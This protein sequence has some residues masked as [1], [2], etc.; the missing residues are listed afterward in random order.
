MLVS[1]KIKDS[2][3]IPNLQSTFLRGLFHFIPLYP[4]GSVTAL[5]EP[6]AQDV[7]LEVGYTVSMGGFKYMGGNKRMIKINVQK[8][9]TR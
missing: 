3:H 9:A 4:F 1:L 7:Y 2:C 8:S 5:A 6:P